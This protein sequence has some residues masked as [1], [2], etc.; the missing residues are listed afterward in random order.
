M[1]DEA[2]AQAL[3]REASLAPLREIEQ[4]LAILTVL[5]AVTGGQSQ[6][7]QVIVGVTQ[8]ANGDFQILKDDEVLD[9][10]NRRKPGSADADDQPTEIAS[11]TITAWI[12]QARETAKKEVKALL[13]P[14]KH[15]IIGDF[16]LFWPGNTKG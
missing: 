12:D 10:L 4:P 16:A 7:R 2:L 9:I 3:E 1:F 11:A 15:P 6:V 8:T 5:D 14:F 13:L